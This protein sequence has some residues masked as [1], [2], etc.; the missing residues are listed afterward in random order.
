MTSIFLQFLTQKISLI[1][2]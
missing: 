1:K 2:R